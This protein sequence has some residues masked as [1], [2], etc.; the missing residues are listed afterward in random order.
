MDCVTHSTIGNITQCTGLASHASISKGYLTGY[1]PAI[2]PF[3]V[4]DIEQCNVSC[5]QAKNVFHPTRGLYGR[6]LMS[7][8]K[9]RVDLFASISLVTGKR[10]KHKLGLD[11][12]REV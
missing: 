6:H 4:E 9:K 11:A 5:L 12:L 10:Q 3:A 2:D 7:V 8:A 1:K